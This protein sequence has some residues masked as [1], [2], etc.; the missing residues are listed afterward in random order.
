MRG[1][2]GMLDEIHIVDV[3]GRMELRHEECVHIPEFG[4]DQRAP[5][6]PKAHAHQ[7][8]F[9]GVQKLTIGMSFSCADPWVRRLMVYFLNRFARQLPSFSISGLSW[10][11]SPQQRHVAPDAPPPRGRLAPL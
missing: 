7:L 2:G 1:T 5:H 11:T 6:F 8:R 3:A 4:L 10:E 9:D